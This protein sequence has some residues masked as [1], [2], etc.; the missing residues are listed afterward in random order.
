[1]SNKELRKALIIRYGVFLRRRW[2]Y[3]LIVLIYFG[4]GIVEEIGYIYKKDMN[5]YV[6]IVG[7]FAM[8][9]VVVISI[10]EIT[11]HEK[12]HYIVP[13]SYDERKRYYLIG[14]LLNITAMTLISLLYIGIS[15]A[16]N[17]E[18][19]QIVMKIYAASG[20]PYFSVASFQK[21]CMFK[22]KKKK[23]N[24][25]YVYISYFFGMVIGILAVV[26]MFQFEFLIKNP[27]YLNLVIVLLNALAISRCIYA[28]MVIIKINTDYENV[29]VNQ[30]KV[31]KKL[32]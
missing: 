24:P 23:D 20:L 1:M 15:I 31:L 16:I 32:M 4:L 6:I 17:R 18:F 11:R 22:G 13:L 26:F 14:V 30:M 25:K 3:L 19:G 12:C 7:V 21:I 28:V 9:G 8:I 2:Y 10:I 5:P 29:K 27:R